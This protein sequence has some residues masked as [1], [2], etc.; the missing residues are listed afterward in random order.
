M[1]TS[2]YIMLPV[3]RIT[4]TKFTRPNVIQALF[5]NFL[6]LGSFISVF[7]IVSVPFYSLRITSYQAWRLQGI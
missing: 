2:Q 7:L 1:K 4:F 5:S 6:V 3:D